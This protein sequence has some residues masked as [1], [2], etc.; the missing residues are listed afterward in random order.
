MPRETYMPN[1]GAL[2]YDDAMGIEISF[3]PP[4]FDLGKL[5][6]M[7]KDYA[8]TAKQY[9]IEANLISDKSTENT[10]ILPENKSKD[11]QFTRDM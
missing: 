4:T 8:N 10:I 5:K 6:D 7:F 3:S 1:F 11:K 2:N 9:L